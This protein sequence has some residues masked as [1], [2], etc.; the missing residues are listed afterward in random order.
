MRPE[1]KASET[2]AA[3]TA[4][5]GNHLQS[6]R[7]A[8]HLIELAKLLPKG[9]YATITLPGWAQFNVLAGPNPAMIPANGHAADV[10]EDILMA[11]LYN[12]GAALQLSSR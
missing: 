11:D 3:C 6:E 9:S 1:T 8:K 7:M 2:L 12:A 10:L 5:T 4:A